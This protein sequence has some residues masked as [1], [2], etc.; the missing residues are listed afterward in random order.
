[1]STVVIHNRPSIIRRLTW[2][3]LFAICGYILARIL[4]FEP[5]I[6]IVFD[7]LKDAAPAFL[8]GLHST[9]DVIRKAA[10]NL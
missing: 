5:L 6:L 1:M 10:G 7:A 9:A 8:D 4:G 3:A 2:S